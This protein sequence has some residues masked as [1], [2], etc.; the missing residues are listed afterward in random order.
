MRT[1][2]EGVLIALKNDLIGAHRPDLDSNCEAVWAQVQLAGCKT[3][4]IGSFYRTPDKKDMKYLQDLHE[5]L[6]KIKNPNDSFI[7]L[8]GDFN[9]GN[10]DWTNQTILP[11][12]N[13]RNVCQQMIDIS[14]FFNLEQVVCEPTRH[15]KILELFFTNNATLV[16]KAKNIP[17][18][19]DH[20]GIPIIT[21]NLCPKRCKQKPRKVYLFHKAD[22]EGMKEELKGFCQKFVVESSPDESVEVLWCKFKENLLSTIG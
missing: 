11:G 1:H 9:L 7:W 6:S 8:G 20:D 17:G 4:T 22:L 16:D 5:T 2:T 13:P 12:P 19:S 10:I 14:N 18:M 15:D 21:V 3:L